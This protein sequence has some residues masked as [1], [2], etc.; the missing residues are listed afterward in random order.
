LFS[1]DNLQS[2]LTPAGPVPQAET[3]FLGL[4]ELLWLEERGYKVGIPVAS[5]SV[6]SVY[7]AI[8]KDT[9]M[10]VAIKA[11]KTKGMAAEDRL[12]L[13]REIQILRGIVHEHIVE[14]V[15]AL[16]TSTHVFIITEL[17]KEDLFERTSRVPLNEDEALDMARMVLKA[18]RICHHKGVAHRDVKLEN[19][20]L[21][22]KNGFHVKLVDFGGAK[23]DLTNGVFDPVKQDPK[24]GF[25]TNFYLPPEVV[26]NKEY[27][28]CL[29]DTWSLGVVMYS[30]MTGHFP[31]FG[32]ST[33]DAHEMIKHSHPRFEEFQWSTVSNETKK[34]I[35]LLL[36][37]DYEE[38]PSASE[39]LRLLDELEAHRKSTSI[40]AGEPANR[41]KKTIFVSFF[42]RKSQKLPLGG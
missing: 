39:A 5:G 29:A 25:G 9:G 40:L 13:R 23:V 22:S 16:E 33:E 26:Q 7:R 42:G 35:Q 2:G 27:V 6:G 3:G 14:Y 32:D 19:I 36:A 15:T 1:L 18:L 4:K 38:R 21:S 24:D 12:R 28:P 11:I 31:F 34:F 8:E 37:K 10:A 20:M 17:L 41:R 30:A